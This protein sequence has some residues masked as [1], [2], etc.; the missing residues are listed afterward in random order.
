MTPSHGATTN[1]VRCLETR[2]EL[3]AAEVSSV[4]GTFTVYDAAEVVDPADHVVAKVS[5]SVLAGHKAA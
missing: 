5:K 1:L 2:Y 3:N 4:R